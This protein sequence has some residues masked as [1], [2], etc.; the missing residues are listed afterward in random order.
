MGGRLDATNVIDPLVAVIADISLDHQRYLGN[1]IAEI[2]REKAGIIRENGVVVTLPQHPEAN[3][4]LGHAIQDHN[5]RGV[6]AVPYMPPLSPGAE[7]LLAGRT[8]QVSG[9]SRYPLMAMGE[10]IEVDSPLVGRHQVRNIALAIATV[11]QLGQFGFKVTAK[12]VERGIRDTHWPGR[13]QVIAPSAATQQREMVF[14]VAHN[15]AGAWALRSA[16]VRNFLRPRA[17]LCLCRDARQSSTGDVRN[18]FPAGGAGSGD[19]RGQSAS[20]NYERIA[21]G[22]TAHGNTAARRSH[23]PGGAGARSRHEQARGPDCGDRIHLS[24]R[25]GDVT[26]RRFSIAMPATTQNESNQVIPE[27]GLCSRLRSYFLFVPIIYLYTASWERCL[28]CRHSLTVTAHAALVRA[29]WA[30]MILA[31]LGP[32]RT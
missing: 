9:R 22:G 32:C 20:S 8:L 17:D 14:D 7:V 6:S 30:R 13:F 4:V 29:H 31:T 12:Q 2:A 23:G 16:T 10:E 25:R 27:G 15:P 19:T 1:S 21:A 24:C 11:E 28:C 26:P 18:S 3:D 5:A